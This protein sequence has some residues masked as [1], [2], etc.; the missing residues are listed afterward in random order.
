[1]LRLP[2]CLMGWQGNRAEFWGGDNQGSG[3]DSGRA[4]HAAAPRHP[5][6]AAHVTLRTDSVSL[7]P[8]SRLP[9]QTHG[10]PP[11]QCNASLD[12]VRKYDRNRESPEVRPAAPRQPPRSVPALAPRLLLLSWACW[13]RGGGRAPA[14]TAPRAGP[15]ASL[16]DGPMCEMLWND[17]QD[18]PGMMPNKVRPGAV[19]LGATHPNRQA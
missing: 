8:S 19:S 13:G 12:Q 11:V 4:V 6:G 16:Q 14:V 7:A 17:P 15:P 9:L 3:K 1:M 2:G 5:L 10:G 18:Q